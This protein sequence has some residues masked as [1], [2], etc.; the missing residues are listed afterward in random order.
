ML[1][2]L[3]MGHYWQVM[4]DEVQI[5]I[6]Q[7]LTYLCC[8]ESTHF[9][10]CERPANSRSVLHSLVAQLLF[11]TFHMFSFYP[12][13]YYQ[14]VLSNYT[15]FALFSLLFT[16]TQLNY[17]STKTA[18]L[19]RQCSLESGFQELCNGTSF[20]SVQSLLAEIQAI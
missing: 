12:I 13:M 9:L 15:V 17:P 5:Y 14:N 7:C 18:D 3:K 2:W 16:K 1:T 10:V 20:K 19:L 11:K 6:K 4:I 8:T